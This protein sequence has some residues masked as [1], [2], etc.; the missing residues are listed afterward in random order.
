MSDLE[1]LRGTDVTDGTV[2]CILM[3][4]LH[5]KNVVASS[6]REKIEMKCR[7]VK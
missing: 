6:G 5:E 3:A 4:A 2:F 1:N 7:G